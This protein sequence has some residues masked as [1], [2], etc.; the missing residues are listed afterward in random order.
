MREFKL[1]VRRGQGTG[2]RILPI[3]DAMAR[4][5]R[6]VTGSGTDVVALTARAG[7]AAIESYV[8]ETYDAAQVLDLVREYPA[9]DG[10]V[11]ACSSD[12]GPPPGAYAPQPS[13]S[14]C[15]P[16]TLRTWFR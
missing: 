2:R 1:N 11:I 13:P 7:P 5:A 3:T 14:N 10:Y 12:P 4:T 8:D 6:A 15:R 9:L 16:L